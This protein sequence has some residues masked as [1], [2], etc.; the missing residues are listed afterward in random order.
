MT[1]AITRQTATL[2]GLLFLIA[3]ATFFTADTLITGVLALADS[4]AGAS[5]HATALTTAALFAFVCGLAVV[6]IAVLL[7]P[8][9]KGV[10]EPLALGYVALRAAELAAVLVYL[11]VPLVA[12]ELGDALLRGEVHASAAPTLGSLVRAGHEVAL[13]SVILFTGAAGTVFT[14]LL[15]RSRLVPRWIAGLG[16]IGYPVM[17]AA[18]VLYRFGLI[19]QLQGPGSIAAVPVGLFELI[20][21]VWLMARGFSEPAGV[22]P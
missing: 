17:L 2:V 10:S 11:A 19:D 8:L 14:T 13:V 7:Y 5:A 6:G 4:L 1:T 3:T 21:P 15:Y 18:T 12:I 16:L 22:E 9:L 20:L